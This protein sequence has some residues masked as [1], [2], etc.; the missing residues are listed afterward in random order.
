MWPRGVSSAS[1]TSRSSS[2]S[3]EGESGVFIAAGEAEDGVKVGF[4]GEGVLEG[5]ISRQVGDAGQQCWSRD[6]TGEP[7]TGA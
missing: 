4:V 3:S 6:Q 1:W 2:D 7:G 5:G